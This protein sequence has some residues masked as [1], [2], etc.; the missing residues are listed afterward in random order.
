MTW[1][2]SAVR[3]TIM[4][5]ECTTVLQID[6]ITGGVPSIRLNTI[7]KHTLIWLISKFNVTFAEKSWKTDRN[8][9]F[10]HELVNKY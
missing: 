3:S 5:R 10:R 1:T 9:S 2:A 4:C 8:I 6:N 7:E